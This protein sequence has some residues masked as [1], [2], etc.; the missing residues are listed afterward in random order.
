MAESLRNSISEMT[1][2]LDRFF[3]TGY[4]IELGENVYYRG[5]RNGKVLFCALS[6]AERFPTKEDAE[7]FVRR[8]MGYSGLK[9][10]VC[11][12]CWV[13]L[14]IESEVAETDQYWDG[15]RFTEDYRRAITFSS[16]RK[17]TDYQKREQ[18]QEVSMID[19]RAFRR[20]QIVM[21]A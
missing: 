13:L 20:K 8:H 9:A 17:M 7:R 11:E 21:A 18:L 3:H 4:V 6:R 2:D 5:Y 15:R 12:V 14:S 16:Y 1:F 19:M 10:Y